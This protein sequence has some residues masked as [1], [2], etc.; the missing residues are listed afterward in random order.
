MALAAVGAGLAVVAVLAAAA[1][2]LRLPTRLTVALL[3]DDAIDRAIFQ[4][5]AAQ[6]K[7]RRSPL[8]LE[9]VVQDD[10]SQPLAALDG[11]K[12]DLAIAR[13][14]AAVPASARV[15]LILRNDAAVI[16]AAKA[17]GI[18]KTTEFAGRR[19]GISTDVPGTG[20]VFTTLLSYYGLSG[21]QVT[22]VDLALA[23]VPAAF[24][25]GRIDA[26]I[27]MGVPGARALTKTVHAVDTVLHDRV[28]FVGVDDADA[29]AAVHDGL[30]S[31]KIAE[32]A[33]SGR[34]LQ[35]PADVSTIGYGVRLFATD[36]LDE[37]TVAAL[38]RQLLAMK[39]SLAA[40]HSTAANIAPP[41]PDDDNSLVLHAGVKAYLDGDDT[42]FV[43]RYSDYLYLGASL[44][45][46]LASAVALS[47]G[48][49]ASRRRRRT[50]AALFDI[51]DVAAKVPAATTL[52]ELTAIE[53]AASERARLAFRKAA[54]GELRGED[55]AAFGLALTDLR[56]AIAAR[57]TLIVEQQSRYEGRG[58]RGVST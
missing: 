39:S 9:L 53:Q 37:S 45:S 51:Q 5:A 15:V 56:A 11:G 20:D 43:E 13:S 22:R 38:V 3:A 36:A 35:P 47:M 14:D 30:A 10:P 25:D 42:S 50:L 27:L 17:S 34:P 32:G 16:I 4:A 28:V 24:K 23:D 1:Y 6:L 41:D 58:T 12:V 31:T 54:D 48:S 44:A 49:L 57:R 33:F 52:A 19:I 55:I 40:S 2:V 7:T 46:G 29:V 18:T 26:A 21:R 8:R